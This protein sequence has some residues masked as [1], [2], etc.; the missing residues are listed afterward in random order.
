[1]KTLLLLITILVITVGVITVGVIPAYADSPQAFAEH[2]N[3]HVNVDDICSNSHIA[4]HTQYTKIQPLNYSITDGTLV[5]LCGTQE[6]FW[7]D[8]FLETDSAGQLTIEIPK[9][10]LDLKQ[11]DY[12][13]CKDTGLFFVYDTNDV[14]TH[15]IGKQISQTDTSR[16]IQIAW[17]SPVSQIIYFSAAA[18]LYNDEL[19]RSIGIS[20]PQ[21]CIVQYE[22]NN[23]DPTK[24]IPPDF[25]KINERL[26]DFCSK[27][28][29]AKV[30]LPYE[31]TTGTIDTICVSLHGHFFYIILDVDADG[32][33]ILDMP[34]E[35]VRPGAFSVH[36]NFDTDFRDDIP[37]RV[38]VGNPSLP[39]TYFQPNA[40]IYLKDENSIYLIMTISDFD[41]DS[42]TYKIPFLKDDKI[43]HISQLVNLR[44][45]PS[46]PESIL[47]KYSEPLIKK[48]DEDKFNL[49]KS[50]FVSLVKSDNSK[51]V[52]VKPTTAEKLIIRG[53]GHYP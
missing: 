1:M 20:Q 45:H 42:T 11:F 22:S 33:I 24:P 40:D 9:S 16:T 38:F 14:A 39:D 35:L 19:G 30:H 36:H 29:L 17:N 37:R 44:E 43:L 25:D 51:T 53:W 21:V 27:P 48:T 13:D 18:L 49:C 26:I 3:T 6:Y 50:D 28:Y 4:S 15:L 8:I 12:H 46:T 10:Q 32:H 23:Y 41:D 31:I 2:N 52:C 5:A 47:A 7:F 34:N